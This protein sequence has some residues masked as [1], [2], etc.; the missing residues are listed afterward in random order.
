M[1]PQ[2]KIEPE[3]SGGVPDRQI[4]SKHGFIRA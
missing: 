3:M 1:R 2:S 4:V